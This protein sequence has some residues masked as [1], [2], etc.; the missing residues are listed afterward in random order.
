[1]KA[2]PTNY[3][4]TTT[5]TE[6]TTMTQTFQIPCQKCIAR[7][8]AALS[9]DRCQAVEHG[10]L[11]H[12]CPER[13]LGIAVFSERGL[14]VDWSVFPSPGIE[15]VERRMQRAQADTLAGIAVSNSLA[16]SKPMH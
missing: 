3:R 7:I 16:A 4:T 6:N 14:M 5:T 8:A 2:T 10:T 9:T 13:G 1:M 11:L 12:H 15:A